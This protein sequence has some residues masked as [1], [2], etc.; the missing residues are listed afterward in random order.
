[1]PKKLYPLS[2]AQ[3]QTVIDDDFN[4]I[5]VIID[6]FNLPP[7][8]KRDALGALRACNYYIDASLKFVKK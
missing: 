6:M 7:S 8:V 3:A 4:D 5:Y 2:V 1:M